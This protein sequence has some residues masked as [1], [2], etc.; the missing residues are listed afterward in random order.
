MSE[1][2]WSAL[3]LHCIWLGT[4]LRWEINLLQ[5]RADIVPLR[6]AFQS[7][8]GSHTRV[9]VSLAP[10]NTVWIRLLEGRG[11]NNRETPE[12]PEPGPSRA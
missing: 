11:K 5:K 4:E 2:V 8:L 10:L 3:T 12:W 7:Q 1:N 6:S 9:R